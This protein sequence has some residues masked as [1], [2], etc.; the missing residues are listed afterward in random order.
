VAPRPHDR[1]GGPLTDQIAVC[2]VP[3]GRFLR[4]AARARRLA[5][6]PIVIIHVRFLDDHVSGLGAGAVKG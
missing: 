5:R 4:A 3:R 6:I 1:Y 2:S